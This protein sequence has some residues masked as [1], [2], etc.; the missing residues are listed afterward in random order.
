MWQNSDLALALHRAR[1]VGAAGR[2]GP[3]QEH[4]VRPAVRGAVLRPVPAR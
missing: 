1:V 2:R 4:P 3:R